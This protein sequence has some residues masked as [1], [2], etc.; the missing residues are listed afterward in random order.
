MSWPRALEL[1]DKV[2]MQMSHMTSG[3]AIQYLGKLAGAYI[4]SC[5]RWRV[6]QSMLEGHG[7]T[8]ADW[9]EDQLNYELRKWL[10]QC[11]D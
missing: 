4:L 7:P 9:T 11:F 6:E 2:R 5:P 10:N 8:I 3:A 1:A